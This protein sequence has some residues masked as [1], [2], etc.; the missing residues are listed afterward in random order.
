MQI[1]MNTI[2]NLTQAP[3]E[4]LQN[5]NHIIDREVLE[6]VDNK[7]KSQYINF[8]NL[9]QNLLNNIADKYKIVIFQ[10]LLNYVNSN[11]TAVI[12][13]DE[14][15]ISNKKLIEVGTYVYQFFVIDCYNTIIPNYL[16]SINCIDINQFDLYFKNTLNNDISNFKTSFIKIIIKIVDE[17]LRLQNIDKTITKDKNYRELLNRYGFYTELVNYGES[18]GFIFNYFRPV[19]YKNQSEILWRIV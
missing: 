2:D 15:M 9:G 4:Y 5:D 11:Y 13:Y 6:N 8:D 18:T 12:N 1:D 14:A 3:I 10:N 19:F 7:I 17:L 16:N